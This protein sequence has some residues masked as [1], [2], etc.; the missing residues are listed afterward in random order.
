MKLCEIN[1]TVKY[2][3]SCIYLWENI[4]NG[5]KYV[6]QTRNFYNRMSQ[7]RQGFFNRYMKNAVNKH[8]INSFKISILERDIDF[9]NLDNREQYWMDYFE[10]YNS[11]KGYNI[12][13]YASN[14]YGYRHT[15]ETKEKISRVLK[16]KFKDPDY[17]AKFMG[18][19]S[20]MFGKH[21][22]EHSKYLISKSSKELWK[23]EEYR[24]FQTERMIGEN[25]HMFGVHLYGELNGMYGKH[26]TQESKEKISKAVTGKNLGNNYHSKKVLCEETGIIYQSQSEASRA[27]GVTAGAI[28]NACLG[29]SKTCMKLH[30]S[31]V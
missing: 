20:P 10:S 2:N 14:T 22:T 30:W 31:F 17:R 12:C 25:N 8:G 15:K 27:Y 21:H 19:N 23:N 13:R 26:H 24:K 1:D 6:G 3:F 9:Q 28:S 11:D 18:K 5:K 16:E 7:Y 4:N 29:K